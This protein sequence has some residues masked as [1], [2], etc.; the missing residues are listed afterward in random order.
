M[1][2]E[3]AALRMSRKG[4]FSFKRFEAA[5]HR[6]MCSVAA[7]GGTKPGNVPKVAV[8]FTYLLSSMQEPSKRRICECS[9]SLLRNHARCDYYFY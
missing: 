2:R 5:V 9:S 3:M 8:C 4:L 6:K 1:I 7:M